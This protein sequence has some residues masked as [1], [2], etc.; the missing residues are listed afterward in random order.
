SV[1]VT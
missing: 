1:E